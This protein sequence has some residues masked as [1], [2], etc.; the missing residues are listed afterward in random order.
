[1]ADSSVH[2]IPTHLTHGPNDREVITE[3]TES[4]E[5]VD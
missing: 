4:G 2:S 5:T 1:M 3:S